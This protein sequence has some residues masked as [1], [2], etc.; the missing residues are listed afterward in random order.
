[1]KIVRIVLSIIAIIATTAFVTSVV[2]DDNPNKLRTEATEFYEYDNTLSIFAMFTRVI[3]DVDKAKEDLGS[4]FTAQVT[5]L[6]R[7]PSAIFRREYNEEFH[8]DLTTGSITN[9]KVLLGYDGD[10]IFTAIMQSDT[11]CEQQWNK[12]LLYRGNDRLEVVGDLC[13]KE[14][15]Y[16]LPSKYWTYAPQ[17]HEMFS[18]FVESGFKSTPERLTPLL[19]G[20]MLTSLVEVFYMAEKSILNKDFARLTKEK[21]FFL[22]PPVTK[23]DA[24]LNEAHDKYLSVMGIRFIV[25]GL[26][27]VVVTLFWFAGSE[28]SNKEKGG[29]TFEPSADELKKAKE[30]YRKM[31]AREQL[32]LLLTENKVEIAALLDNQDVPNGLKLELGDAYLRARQA[33]SS[34]DEIILAEAKNALTSALSACVS[35]RRQV[36]EKREFALKILEKLEK[37]PEKHRGEVNH[38][39]I[40]DCRERLSGLVGRELRKLVHEIEK[41]GELILP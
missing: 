23:W 19:M 5:L 12:S 6:V 16:S 1:M 26:F 17:I 11:P 13:S 32:E 4:E 29:V 30:N 41:N 33:L 2:L 18:T 14:I 31:T 3:A 27:W 36:L 24:D 20:E 8:G 40:N 22:K 37:V 35:S 9:K 21:G 38:T 7:E 15:S 10:R 39:W 34:A 25:L 28:K